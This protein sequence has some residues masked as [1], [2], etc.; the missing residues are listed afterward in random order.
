MLIAYK[1]RIYPN[2]V[3]KELMAKHFGCA[4]YVYNWGLEKKSKAYQTED[5]NLTCFDLINEMVKLKKIEEYKWLSEVNSQ[6]LQMPLRNLDNAYT[7]FF[8]KRGKFP[9]FKSKSDS[10]QSFQCPQNVHISFDDGHLWLPKFKQPIKAIFHRRFFG[11]I[12]TCTVSVNPAGQYYISALVEDHKIIPV[13]SEISKEKSIGLDLGIKHFVTLSTGEKIENP[14][15]LKKAEKK[16]KRLNRQISKSIKGSKNRDKKR[17][18]LAKAHNKV[19]N[20]RKDFH[21]KLSIKLIREN[22]TICIEDLSIQEMMQKG[23][24]QLSK[25]IG[26]VGWAQFVQFLQYKAEWY[27]R[28][29]VKIGRFEPSSKLCTC[30]KINNSLTLSDREW[31]CS[32]CGTTHDRDVL[33][34]NNILNFALNPKNLIGQELPELE[35]KSSKPS[36]RRCH[37]ASMKQEATSL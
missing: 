14:K 32:G 12:K 34:A 24:S 16:L 3:Q 8:K 31:T 22:Q 33:A 9:K 4:R 5:K 26:N 36:L 23:N 6:S 11:D 7:N 2:L 21:H 27:G 19:V 25:E 37:R 17:K 13:K 15:W 1:Y 35:E 29:I 28:N 30:G 10:H 18:R 20:Q